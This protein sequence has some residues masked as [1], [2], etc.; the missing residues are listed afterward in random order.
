MN[1]DKEIFEIEKIL[2]LKY[3][4][5]ILGKQFFVQTE[6]KDAILYVTVLLKNPSS[7]FYYPVEGRI[8]CMD[9][10]KREDILECFYVL[11]DHIDFYFDEYL[12]SEE[13]VSLPIDWSPYSTQDF[14][15]QLRGQILNLDHENQANALL[16]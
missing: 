11:V 4:Q 12:K 2:N 14:E 5:Y 1:F 13:F 8:D 10:T 16:S 9:K 15:F 6:F 3:S 7:S